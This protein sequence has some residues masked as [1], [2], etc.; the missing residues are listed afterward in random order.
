V[1]L[2]EK[3]KFNVEEKCKNIDDA[4]LYFSY[5]KPNYHSNLKPGIAHMIRENTY[6]ALEIFA[7]GLNEYYSQAKLKH[8]ILIICK[9]FNI[10]IKKLV[11]FRKC[12]CY[13]S[14]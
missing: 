13:N 6:L 11:I 14:I 3:L 4:G 10:N 2:L 5:C 1:K 8:Y 9:N 7:I 12:I